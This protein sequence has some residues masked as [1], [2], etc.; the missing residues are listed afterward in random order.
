MVTKI[1]KWGKSLALR[2]PKTLAQE[3]GLHEGLIVNL[4]L[5]SGKLMVSPSLASPSLA[6]LLR[7]VTKDNLHGQ[8]DS[9]PARGREAW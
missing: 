9:G 4:R 7:G 1:R 5:E 6:E 3:A 8:I 2:I